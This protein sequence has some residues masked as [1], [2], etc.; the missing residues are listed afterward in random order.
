MIYN[1]IIV[2]Y[3][4]KITH[5]YNQGIVMKIILIMLTIATNALALSFD[6][7]NNTDKDITVSAIFDSCMENWKFDTSTTLLI[8]KR[9]HVPVSKGA[10]GY[11]C[12]SGIKLYINNTWKNIHGPFL[13]CIGGSYDINQDHL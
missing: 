5:T 2:I 4:Y 12:L 13:N 11:C 3:T 6:I 10:N 8:K 9:E 7:K 1:V